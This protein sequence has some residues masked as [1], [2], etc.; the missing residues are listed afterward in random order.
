MLSVALD[1]FIIDTG[2]DGEVFNMD[3]KQ[4]GGLATKRW[5]RHLWELCTFLNAR[6][7]GKFTRHFHP[8]RKGDVPFMAE[9]IVRNKNAKCLGS[10]DLEI[11]GRYWKFKKVYFLSE[12]T[13]CDGATVDREVLQHSKGRSDWRYQKRNNY[14]ST[15]SCGRKQLD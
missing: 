7:Q 15:C 2:L 1:T 13:L 12:I 14:A 3:F 9:L 8:I 11:V 10:K 5:Y 4:H 6:I